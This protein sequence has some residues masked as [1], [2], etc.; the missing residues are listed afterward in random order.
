MDE[1]SRAAATVGPANTFTLDGVF[2][3]DGKLEQFTAALV[4]PPRWD[5]YEELHFTEAEARRVARGVNRAW[6]EPVWT[7][8]ETRRAFRNERGDGDVAAERVDGVEMWELRV[9]G[10]EYL[11][12][13]E[14]PESDD[15]E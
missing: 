12:V 10:I 11:P 3:P 14:W 2:G 13:G 7:F 15:N 6:G 1:S 4:V 8:D 5:D 9:D